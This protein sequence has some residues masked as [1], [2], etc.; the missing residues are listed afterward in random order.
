MDF[1][2]QNKKAIICGLVIAVAI[3]ALFALNVM[4]ENFDVSF[5][6]DPTTSNSPNKYL[7]RFGITRRVLIVLCAIFGTV[8]LGALVYFLMKKKTSKTESLP[9]S[10]ETETDTDFE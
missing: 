1:I 5:F 6:E 9:V 2:N 7:L 10:T 3:S 4:K 8:V